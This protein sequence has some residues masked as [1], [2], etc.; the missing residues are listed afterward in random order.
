ML[1]I[2]PIDFIRQA[3]EQE[4]LKEHIKNPNYFGGKNQVNLFS[5]YEQLKSQDEV[6]RFVENYR[7]LSEQQ[8]RTGLILNGVLVSPE[9][10]SITNL[11]SSLIIPM[12]FTC[13]FRCML[14][15]RDQAIETIN[16]LIEELKGRKVDMAQLKCTDLNGKTCYKPFVVG[17]IGDND[18][19]PQ[20]KNGDY[21]G[22]FDNL[23]NITTKINN[24]LSNGVGIDY[25]TLDYLYCKYQNKLQVLKVNISAG[26][27]VCD[28]TATNPQVYDDIDIIFEVAL[29]GVYTRE[30]LYPLASASFYFYGDETYSVEL[31][32]G[33][34]DAI[35]NDTY[36]DEQITWVR[37]KFTLEDTINNLCPNWD[38]TY[39]IE[40]EF[41]YALDHSFDLVVDDGTMP[42]IIFP[43]EHTSFEKYKLS[44]S[45]DAI[46]CDEPR[47][48][49]ANEYCEITFSGSATLVSNGVA[50]GN[51]LIKIYVGK[52]GYMAETFVSFDDIQS[53]NKYAWLEPLELPS[54]SNANT[55][56]NQ[57]VSNRFKT[58]THTD[59]L[60]LTLQ[61]T[62][63]LDRNISLLNQWFKYARYGTQGLT[64]NDITPNLIY[65]VSELWSSWGDFEV[66]NFIAKIV[67]N[68]DIENTESD[69]LT[70][71]LIMQIQG[72]NNGGLS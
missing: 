55:K 69:T 45:F 20:L 7:E 49:N 40:D 72:E 46:R 68:I 12:T 71:S 52:N 1:K 31:D 24:L 2:F 4:L 17:T 27:N 62:F 6:D 47:N 57:L 36:N 65:N 44:F 10:P 30:Q 61:Y 16:N 39:D 38:G 29:D 63:V 64:V 28:S 58:N 22:D 35:W 32:N 70:L 8:N 42:N 59:S 26:E 18:G 43:P 9:N 54:G 3:I 37:L 13:S 51:D 21:I 25:D 48:L 33:I 19:A 53:E 60:A 34:I 11:Y 5:F 67:E 41:V 23:A 15:N 14:E 56:L 66:N 50:L